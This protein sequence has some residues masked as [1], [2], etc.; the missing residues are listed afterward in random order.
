MEVVIIT[1]AS[2]GLGEALV[3]A[4]LGPD[5]RVIGIAR[6]PNAALEAHARALG[7]WL[8]WYL[9][10][11]AEPY[12]TDALARS[13]AHDM[14]QDA[15]RYVL[16]NNAATL[17][18]IGAASTLEAGAAAQ[19]FNLNVTAAMLF[20]ARFLEATDTLDVPRQIVSIS[21]GAARNPL[22][23]WGVYCASKAALD[24]F[25]RVVNK[26]QANRPN[27]ATLVSLAPGIIDTDMQGL[28]RAASPN[29]FPDVERFRLMKEKG[30]LVTPE[31]TALR[32][33]AYLE[34]SD[35]GTS[36]IDDLRNY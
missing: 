13:I 35:F 23:G 18:P 2:R 25:T 20:A 30:Q 21:S 31:A 1:G 19:A 32:I 14:P 8:D 9:E 12:A 3:R 6:S 29:Q 5:C 10:D 16:I 34:R 15:T 36:E 7:G 4:Y 11:L 33:K 28:V 22:A 27:R 26:E 17:G 24:M